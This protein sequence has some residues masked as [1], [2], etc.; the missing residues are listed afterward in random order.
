MGYEP[1][2]NPMPYTGHDGCLYFDLDEGDIIMP[3]DFTWDNGWALA[4]DGFGA[5]VPNSASPLHRQ[6]RRRAIW[7]PM[8]PYARGQGDGP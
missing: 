4:T 8:T 7:P 1:T 2:D 5:P 6:Y 3:G